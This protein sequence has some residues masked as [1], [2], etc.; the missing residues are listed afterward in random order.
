MLINTVLG[1]VR[2]VVRDLDEVNLVLDCGNGP[3][4]GFKAL[5]SARN[6][7]NLWELDE[8][9]LWLRFAEHCPPPSYHDFSAAVLEMFQSA[10]DTMLLNRSAFVSTQIEFLAKKIVGCDT[11]IA[12]LQGE[13]NRL[14]GERRQLNE[15]ITSLHLSS[16]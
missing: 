5:V 2:V 1:R 9:S 10:L 11:K 7:G 8:S 4:G 3:H 12:S 6:T 13:I 15:A 16:L 14:V